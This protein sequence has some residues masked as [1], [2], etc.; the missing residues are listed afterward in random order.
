[1]KENPATMSAVIGYFANVC[2]WRRWAVAFF[3]GAGAA[4]SMAPFYFFPLLVAGYTILAVFIDASKKQKRPRFSAFI[5]GWWFGFGYFLLGIYWMAFSF[6]VQADEFAWMA[7][8]AI[9]ALPAFLALF[10]A[11]AS[12]L[13]CAFWPHGWRRIIFFTVIFASFE[14]L[15]GHVLTGL[16]WNLSGQA[17]AGA[18]IW[19]QTAAWY[20]AYGLSFVVILIC[21][22]PMLG[23]SDAGN[24]FNWKKGVLPPVIAIAFLLLVGWLRLIGI[25]SGPQKEISLRV[26]Q[27]NISQREKI[28]PSFWGENFNKQL[29]LS[30]STNSND[31]NLIIIWPE[32][33]VPL[34][35]E[36]QRAMTILATSLPEKSVLVAGAVRRTNANNGA[37]SFYNSISIASPVGDSLLITGQYDKHHLVPFGEYLPFFGILDAVGLAQLTPYGDAG[38]ARGE[39]PATFKIAGAEFA[40]LI[41]YE[42]IFPGEIYPKGQR[43]DGIITVTNDA[44][45]GDSSGPRQHLDQARLRSIESGLPMARSANT[46]ISAVID[47]KGRIIEKLPLYERGK[48][49][50]PLPRKLSQTLYGVVGDWLFGAMC[51]V[52]LIVSRTRK[53]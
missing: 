4:L 2:G 14:F 45:F 36:S 40:L 50:A 51:L 18:A 25:E 39:G 28:D 43:P 30:Q 8:F 37:Q 32:N 49:D 13:S 19:A 3:A 41:C 24:N 21:V 48:I 31:H 17:L 46:G 11:A 29:S 26:V 47:A 5:A 16:P 44:W 27:P 23:V 33:G 15:R 20:G 6:F 42:A 38:F 22:L 53:K 52:G 10:T 9:T 34:L 1:M 35:D 12:A 7:P